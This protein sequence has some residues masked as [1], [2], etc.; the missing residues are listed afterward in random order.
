VHIRHIDPVTGDFL[1]ID[2]DRQ[3]R[4]PGNLFDLDVFHPFHRPHQVCNGFGVLIQQVEI[5]TE[6]LDGAFGPD[7]LRSIHRPAPESADSSG[8]KYRESP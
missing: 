2:V 6:Q 4:L 8:R 5:L 7:A 3:I 1:T